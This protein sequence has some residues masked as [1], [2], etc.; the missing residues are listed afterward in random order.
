[1]HKTELMKLLAGAGVASL[2][3]T[4][5]HSPFINPIEEAFRFIKAPLRNRHFFDE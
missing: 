5:P 4:G 3:F 2:T 1:M